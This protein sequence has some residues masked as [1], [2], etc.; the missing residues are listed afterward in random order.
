MGWVLRGI[1]GWRGIGGWRGGSADIGRICRVG[2][3][4]AV[5]CIF[6]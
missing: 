5:V 2:I 6:R 1:N 4:E 3:G